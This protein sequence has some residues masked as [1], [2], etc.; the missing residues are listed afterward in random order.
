MN[1]NLAETEGQSNTYNVSLHRLHLH[2]SAV[3]ETPNTVNHA[4]LIPWQS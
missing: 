2:L 1:K 3:I 4:V